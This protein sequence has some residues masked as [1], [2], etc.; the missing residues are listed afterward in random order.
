MRFRIMYYGGVF[1]G[2]F[3]H[4]CKAKRATMVTENTFCVDVAIK[5]SADFLPEFLK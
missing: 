1:D 4:R 3:I 5:F 2:V